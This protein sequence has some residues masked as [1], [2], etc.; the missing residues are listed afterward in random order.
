[1][2]GQKV[3]RDTPGMDKAGSLFALCGKRCV[4][5]G[6]AVANSRLYN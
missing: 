3:G 1:M 2:D 6:A 5:S 4:D